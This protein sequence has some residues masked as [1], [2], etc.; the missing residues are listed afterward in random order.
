MGLGDFLN[1]VFGSENEFQA[2]EAQVDPN[3][4]EYGGYKGGAQAAQ[5]MYGVQGDA[6]RTQAQ[7]YQEQNRNL[8]N[9]GGNS[10]N[11]AGQARQDQMGL[12]AAMRARAMGQTPSIAQMQADRQMGQV[13]AEQASAASSA[14]GPAAMALA[15]QNAAG[16][17]ANAQSNISGQAQINAANERMQAEQAAMGAYSGIRGQ[18]YQGA[19][20]AYGAAAN[21]ANAQA[22]Q[23]QLAQ[24]YSQLQKSVGDSQLAAQQNQAQ[25]KSANANQAQG[26]NAGV[27]GQNAGAGQAMGGAALSATAGATASAVGAAAKAEGGPIEDRKP[28][29]VGEEGPELVIPKQ[30]GFV[31]PA[32]QTRALLSAM[33]KSDLQDSNRAVARQDGGPVQ[34]GGAAGFVPAMST[35]GSHPADIEGQRAAYNQAAEQASQAQAAYNQA[36]AAKRREQAETTL[37]QARAAGMEG[38]AQ[39]V[40]GSNLTYKNPYQR[41]AD[42]VAALR[43]ATPDLVDESDLE[44]ER[45]AKAMDRYAR[46]RAGQAPA[47]EE[48]ADKKASAKDAPK[49]DAKEAPRADKTTAT[50][51]AVSGFGQGLTDGLKTKPVGYQPVQVAAPPQFIGLPARAEGGPIEAGGASM[52]P[53]LLAALKMPAGK[54]APDGSYTASVPMANVPGFELHQSREGRAGY[55]PVQD[56][57][58]PPRDRG[59]EGASAGESASKKPAVSLSGATKRKPTPDEASREL[60][61]LLAQQQAQ[62][63]VNSAAQGAA[64]RSRELPP[65]WLDAVMAGNARAMGGPM[66]GNEAASPYVLTSGGGMDVMATLRKNNEPIQEMMANPRAKTRF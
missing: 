42:R 30:D 14:R 25:L 38:N 48:S 51:A 43:A 65:G 20:T 53:R 44:A 39:S 5:N 45:R 49:A 55:L 29:L 40:L 11:L 24:G 58:R 18:D 34:A 35:W 27:A 60:D 9:R 31:I 32:G 26:I 12:A 50:S 57:E 10:M 54:Y 2:K 6:H 21:A 13:A 56:Q 52:T 4:F 66:V 28:Y 41:D 1:D 62:L 8:Y 3:A 19:Q 16:N 33:K 64:D 7:E 15:Q 47:E 61:K 46:R 59:G 22:Q 17:V 37:V 36:E 63:A 23:G